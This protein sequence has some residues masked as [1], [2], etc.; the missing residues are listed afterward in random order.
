MAEL[1]WQSFAMSFDWDWEDVSWPQVT[2]ESP[3]SILGRAGFDVRTTAG[4]ALGGA[5]HVEPQ[6]MVYE[7]EAQNEV[8]DI[9]GVGYKE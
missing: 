3:V 1:S 7:E 2:A 8:L 6:A 4:R 5:Q 9:V